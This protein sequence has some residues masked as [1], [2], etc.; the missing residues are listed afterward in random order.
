MVF[1]LDGYNVIHRVPGLREH[2]ARSLEAGRRALI[3]CCREWLST[4]RDV[5]QFWIVFDGDSLGGEG[6]SGA[7]GIR[8]MFSG[9]GET[10]DERIIS[11]MEE[12]GRYAKHTVVSDDN[13]VTR[14]A[15][16]LGARIMTASEFVGTARR[17]SRQAG[18]RR[19]DDSKVSERE[20]RMINES[21]KRE[22]GIE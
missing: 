15:G 12:V 2:L 7:M 16:L 17:K 1:I 5:S 8:V 6:S 13:E 3:Q 19:D 4:R 21:L 10:A 20:Q 11:I 22:W 9:R 18:V 14:K